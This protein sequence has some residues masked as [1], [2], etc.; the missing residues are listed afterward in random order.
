MSVFSKGL[1]S[2]LQALACFELWHPILKENINV[3]IKGG[4]SANSVFTF[5]SLEKTTQY[6]VCVIK[7]VSDYHFINFCKLGVLKMH[8]ADIWHLL[9]SSHLR[10]SL[11]RGLHREE[12]CQSWQCPALANADV[13]LKDGVLPPCG[14]C[15]QPQLR[16][17]TNMSK[18]WGI[19]RAGE[20]MW[21][22]P[23]YPH[24]LLRLCTQWSTTDMS[25]GPMVH[26]LPMVGN[27]C[28]RDTLEEAIV[29][30]LTWSGQKRKQTMEL[31]DLA[32]YWC[33]HCCLLLHWTAGLT[34]N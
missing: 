17:G 32:F 7:L 15:P 22:S 21:P 6:K 10:W 18:L 13:L 9:S 11:R 34:Y 24:A 14:S 31:Q 27:W 33:P 19:L 2:I 23:C 16:L 5:R 12:M 4:D 29:R 28:A 1:E 3:F 26:S 8:L 30:T 20:A 25:A